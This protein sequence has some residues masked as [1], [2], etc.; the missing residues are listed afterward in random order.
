MSLRICLLLVAF[1]LA[2]SGGELLYQSSQLPAWTDAAKAEEVQSWPAPDEVTGPGYQAYYQRWARA[3]DALRTQK[4]PLKDA[5]ATLAALGLCLAVAIFLLGIHA[6]S[7]LTGLKTPRRRWAIYGLGALGWFGYWT[8]SVAAMVEG[9]NRFEFPTWSDTMFVPMIAIAAFAVIGWVIISIGAWVV[10]RHAQLPASLW[11]W[12]KDLP[13]HTWLSFVGAA[14][15]IAL[16]LEGLRETYFY[17]HWLA[18]PA[19]VVWIYAILAGRA[20]AI[21]RVNAPR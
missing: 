3:I 13:L 5:G 16:S 17:G 9:F 11:I 10:L 14:F 1:V 4:Y 21:S 7:D 2:V 19:I 6:P 8:S 18:V 12:R 15:S 20:A